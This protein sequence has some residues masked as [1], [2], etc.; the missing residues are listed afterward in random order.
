MLGLKVSLFDVSDVSNPVETAFYELEE[1]YVR[2]IAEFEH[3][4][5]LFSKSKE[6]LVVPGSYGAKTL[7][8]TYNGALV[9]NIKKDSITLKGI[10]NHMIQPTDNFFKRFVERSLY[11]EN[12]LYTKSSCLMKINIIEDLTDLRNIDL[13]SPNIPVIT[14]LT[15]QGTSG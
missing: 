14:Q 6:L 11:I 1:K 7:A 3:K 8:D 2:S 12:L 13:C 9:F 15:G 5:F 10:V 4:A